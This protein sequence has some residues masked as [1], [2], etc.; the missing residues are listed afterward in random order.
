MILVFVRQIHIHQIGIAALVKS[1]RFFTHLEL[2]LPFNTLTELIKILHS[3][4]CQFLE[5]L[6]LSKV[7][8]YEISHEVD[9]QIIQVY[10]TIAL[11]PLHHLVHLDLSLNRFVNETFL[12]FF[13]DFVPN[14]K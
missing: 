1:R 9:E 13:L 4:Y 14:I 10:T 11:K 5:T 8:K 7:Y 2:S 12:R 3:P 6:I